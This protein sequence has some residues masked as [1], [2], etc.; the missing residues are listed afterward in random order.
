MESRVTGGGGVSV[1]SGTYEASGKHRRDI[2]SVKK[3]VP[4]GLLH[5]ILFLLLLFL[6][7]LFTYQYL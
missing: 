5:F 2:V 3:I 6:L 4:V 7:V 1:V